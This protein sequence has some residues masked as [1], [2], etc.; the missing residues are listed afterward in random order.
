MV[1]LRIITSKLRLALSFLTRRV[2]L[3][4]A[5]FT[6]LRIA[7]RAA[8]AAA[9]EDRR[10][11]PVLCFGDSITEGYFNIWPHPEHAPG[12]TLPTDRTIN[13]N[14]HEKLLCHPYAIHLGLALASDAG[15]AAEG[16][17]ASLR[18]ARAR[19]FSG[20]T[21]AELLPELRRC[22]REGGWRCAVILA[23]S[24]DCLMEGVTDANLIL[25]RMDLL[26]EACDA[27]GVPVV[28][29]TNLDVDTAHHGMVPPELQETYRSTVAAVAAGVAERAHAAGRPLVDARSALPLCAQYYDDSLHPSPA[30]A[31]KLA[32][33]VH[34]AIRRRS[35]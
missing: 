13:L 17:K 12:R 19:G 27:A 29:V 8:A 10:S 25:S 1:A 24:N 11:C 14:E 23:G 22:L 3:A 20:W 33:E 15:D 4:V 31:R 18:Y 16:Y 34:T 6:R 32:D 2:N 7:S 30:G 5:F 35:W 9:P 26:Y 21:A 28:C